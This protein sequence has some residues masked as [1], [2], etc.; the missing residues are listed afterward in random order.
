MGLLDT[1]KEKAK[2]VYGQGLLNQVITNPASVGQE[3]SQLFD[4]NYMRQVKPM[5]QEEAL[6]VALSAPMMLGTLKN[7]QLDK[8]AKEKFG[9]TF[10]PA[11]TG[12]IMDDLS[13]LDFTGRNE[14]QRYRNIANRFIPESGKPDYL[15]MQRSTDHRAVHSLIPEQ[16]YGWEGLSKF[17]DETGAIRYDADTGISLVNTNKP[18]PAQIERVVNDFRKSNTPLI[19]D[20]DRAKDGQNLASKEFINPTVDQVKRWVNKQYK[21][22]LE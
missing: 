19:I 21:G 12:F 4:P 6:D 15:K 18:N 8:L 22:L 14:A 20:I 5:S 3:L 9:T 10:Y 2:Q 1:L 13:R 11:E 16:N 7:A 17:M